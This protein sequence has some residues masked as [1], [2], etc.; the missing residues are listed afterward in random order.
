MKQ[1]EHIFKEKGVD[2]S[3]RKERNLLELKGVEFI[4][5]LKKRKKHLLCIN[6]DSLERI[7]KQ[8]FDFFEKDKN[9]FIKPF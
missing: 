1:H 2:I 8:W 7:I 3:M 9:W 5:S 4:K 6:T